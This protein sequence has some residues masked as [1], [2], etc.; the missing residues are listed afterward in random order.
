[1]LLLLY[2][3]LADSYMHNTTVHELLHE[4]PT[5]Y[6]YRLRDKIVY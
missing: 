4:N 5:D 3:L 2:K 1:M 6:Q